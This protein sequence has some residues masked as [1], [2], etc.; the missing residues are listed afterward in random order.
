MVKKRI[1]PLQRGKEIYDDYLQKYDDNNFV[2]DN[3]REY[4]ESILMATHGA[5]FVTY[6]SRIPLFHTYIMLYKAEKYNCRLKIKMNPEYL[7]GNDLVEYLKNNPPEVIDGIE[8]PSIAGT[9]AG[10]CDGWEYHFELDI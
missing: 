4:I 8:M 1:Y 6:D 3:E 2:D 10:Q 9:R 5:H 7:S